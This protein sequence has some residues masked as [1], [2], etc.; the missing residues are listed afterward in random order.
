[1]WLSQVGIRILESGGDPLSLE[2]V[3]IGCVSTRVFV[4][5]IRRI[6]ARPPREQKPLGKPVPGTVPGAPDSTGRPDLDLPA[7]RRF[8]M[9][10]ARAGRPASHTS[11]ELFQQCGFRPQQSPP[12][13]GQHF[14]STRRRRRASANQPLRMPRVCGGRVV[15]GAMWQAAKR[16]QTQLEW[17]C[18]CLPA[19]EC[20]AC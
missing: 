7:F 16:R 12:P 17:G 6:S 15:C 13:R 2:T 14:N 1:M 3:P 19:L 4:C 11:S 18:A 10:T 8:Y 5:R 20:S 9:I